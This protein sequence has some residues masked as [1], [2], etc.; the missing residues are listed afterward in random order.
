VIRRF[1]QSIPRGSQAGTAATLTAIIAALTLVVVDATASS[2]GL[3]ATAVQITDHPAYVQTVVDFSGTA[4]AFNQVQATD[5]DPS[6][7]TARLLVS[8]SGATTQVSV[9][10]ANHITLR[11]V[12]TPSGLDI[13]LGSARGAFKYLSYRLTG[14]NAL[15]IRLWKRTFA[16]AGNVTRGSGRCLTLGQV[17]VSPGTVTAS[18]TAHGLFE[19][20]FRVVLRDVF[21]DPLATLR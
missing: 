14:G 16:P 5:P 8:V 7:G 2:P 12:A 10:S 6:D 18:G 11:V 19:N 15:T 17:S 1:L 9:R 20:R 3:T 21:G 13:D 4:L